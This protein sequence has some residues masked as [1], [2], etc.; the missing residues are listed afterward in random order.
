MSIRQS[1]NYAAVAMLFCSSFVFAQEGGR[2]QETGARRA[3]IAACAGGPLG[4]GTGGD[5]EVTGP[6]TVAA[7]TYQYR[8]VNIYAG[9]S[10]TFSDAVIDFWA[11]SILVENHGSL[12]AGSVAHPIG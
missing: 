6:C 8:N 7:G 5:L 10:L 1:G 11:Q 12:V 2:V 9:G 3:A 4:P